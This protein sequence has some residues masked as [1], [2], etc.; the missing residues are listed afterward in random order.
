[1]SDLREDVREIAKELSYPSAAKLRSALVR[2]GIRISL[3]EARRYTRGLASRQVFQKVPNVFGRIVAS[4][5]N[6]RWAADLI[7]FAA[8]P[9]GDFQ[10][11]LA[12]QDIFTRELFT[13]P[14]KKNDPD[15]VLRAFK[16]FVSREGQPS[17]VDTDAGPEFTRSF[18]EYLEEVLDAEHVVKDPSD[19]NAIATLDKAIQTIKQDLARVMTEEESDDWVELL[20][21]ITRAYNS[22]PHSSLFGVS[23]GEV[24]GNDDIQFSLKQKALKD[25]QVNDALIERRASAVLREG[26]FRVAAKR[27]KFKRSFQPNWSKD[28]R[29]VAG[30]SIGRV[31]D[32][33]GE[34]TLLKRVLPVPQEGSREVRLPRL[35]MPG[36]AQTDNRQKALLEPFREKLLDFVE[37]TSEALLENV[38]VRMRA[39]GVP[40]IPGKTV[41][42]T[43]E[44]MGFRVVPRFPE[45]PARGF[46]VRPPTDEG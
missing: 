22:R 25:G 29:E 35:A 19:V 2:R 46:V 41:R 12:V 34:S 14:L 24:R 9:D 7:D 20:P 37:H 36:S 33:K 3:E 17:R 5:P 40:K 13:A 16:G 42:A 27:D 15:E 21:R 31:F 4:R 45:N 32:T 28:V 6:Q 30:V 39:L 44:M 1:M 18:A 8:S 23:P 11:V 38:S 10:Y 43:L 26:A